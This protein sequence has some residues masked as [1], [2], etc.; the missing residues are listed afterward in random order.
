ML[1]S[2]PQAEPPAAAQPAAPAAAAAAAAE[3]QQQPY[4]DEMARLG[5]MLAKGV[6]D[7]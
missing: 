3:Q 6:G 7:H 1:P 5:V 4:A 2:A